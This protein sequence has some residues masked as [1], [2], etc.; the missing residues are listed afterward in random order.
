MHLL[1][2]EMHKKCSFDVQGAWDSLNTTLTT[3]NKG[4]F[5]NVNNELVIILTNS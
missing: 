5:F 1:F 4:R 2:F 3:V